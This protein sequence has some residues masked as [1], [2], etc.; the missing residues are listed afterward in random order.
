[1]PRSIEDDSECQMYLAVLAM[2]RGWYGPY[3][4]VLFLSNQ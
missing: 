1:M 4:K 3:C 2:V